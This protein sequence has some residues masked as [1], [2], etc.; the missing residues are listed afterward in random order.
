MKLFFEKP[1]HSECPLHTHWLLINAVLFC[2]FRFIRNQWTPNAHTHTHTHIQPP[3]LHPALTRQKS[4]NKNWIHTY[5]RHKLF[6]FNKV[7]PSSS[8]TFTVHKWC[9]SYRLLL[10]YICGYKIMVTIRS[11]VNPNPC[12]L[13]LIYN[14]TDTIVFTSYLHF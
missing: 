13:C 3:V 8:L 2:S 4:E 11:D 1:R 5:E 9:R 14:I 12:F 6:S 10:L 7:T